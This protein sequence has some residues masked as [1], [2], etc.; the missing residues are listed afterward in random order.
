MDFS[1]RYAFD[2]PTRVVTQPV[3]TDLVVGESTGAGCVPFWI[4]SQSGEF[5]F[6]PCEIGDALQT[7]APEKGEPLIIRRKL[8]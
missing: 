5:D 4:E 1:R 2:D 7:R 3:H 8:L 6:R